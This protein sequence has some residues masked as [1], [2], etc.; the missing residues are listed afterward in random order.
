VARHCAIQ[1]LGGFA[2]AVDGQPVEADAWR[3]RR[4]AD[5]VKLLALAPGHRLHREQV[6]ASLWP[7][8]E[9]GAASANLRKAIHFARRALG[10]ADAI[11]ARSEVLELWPRAEL[12]VDVERFEAAARASAVARSSDD[13]PA[14]EF[15]GELLPEDRYADW[16]EPRREH[17]TTLATDLLRRA[18]RWDRV[19]EIDRTDEEAHRALMQRHLDAGDHQAAIRQFQR[20]RGILRADLGVGPEPETVALFERALAAKA[21]QAPSFGERAQ[22]LIARGLLA[23]NRR[24]LTE[25]ERLADDARS[26]AREHH[27]GRELGEACALLGL[28]AFARGRWRER[29]RKD[30]DDAIGLAPGESAFIFDAH[31]CLA[32]TTMSGVDADTVVAE[33]KDL[34][35][36]AG[37]AGSAHGQA[38]ASL[39]IGEFELFSGHMRESRAWLS[40]AV[41]LFGKAGA[42]SGRALAMVRLAESASGQ[43]DGTEVESLLAGARVLAERSELGPHLLTRVFAGMIQSATSIDDKVLVLAESERRLRPD[44][45]C[46]PCSIGLCVIATITCARAGELPRAR[47]F[48]ADAERLAG[49]W[50]GGPWRAAA[51]EARAFVRLAEGDIKQAA[52]LL[53]EAAQLFAQS[54]RALDDRRCRDEAERLGS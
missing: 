1:L 10:S 19:L 9:S 40:S 35:A 16:T 50:Q 6:M 27:L 34:V 21:P 2:V 23:W 25:A 3:H 44:E 48:L 53:L 28:T 8:L 11:A 30:F 37:R 12:V 22:T 13:P 39:L 42:D 29:F 54:G 51:W 46:G 18:A 47:R 43:P 52:A 45:V 36:T 17:L 20:L 7:D 14:L 26:L 5:L 38:L 41:D 49:M 24:D 31:L 4:G 32:E 15:A 33:A